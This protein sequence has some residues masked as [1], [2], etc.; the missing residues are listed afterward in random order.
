M[1][2]ARSRLNEGLGASESGVLENVE[3]E[4]CNAVNSPDIV[5]TGCRDI[6]D[7]T[8][9]DEDVQHSRTPFGDIQPLR[10]TEG[11]L[12]QNLE[13]STITYDQPQCFEWIH[14]SRATRNLHR[15]TDLSFVDHHWLC[16]MGVQFTHKSNIMSWPTGISFPL[17]LGVNWV[18]AI[19]GFKTAARSLVLFAEGSTKASGPS[20]KC[21]KFSGRIT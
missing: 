18:I 8:S 3:H 10:G 13:Y 21:L 14:K 7:C 2:E 20:L 11:L 1:V 12:A 15:S 4:G 6:D 19:P 16:V 9:L 17:T 5:G